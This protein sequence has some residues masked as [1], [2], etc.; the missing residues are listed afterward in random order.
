[1]LSIN[2][3]LKNVSL[4]HRLTLVNII[5][6]IAIMLVLTFLIKV[7]FTHIMIENAQKE[8][9]VRFQQVSAGCAQ[10]FQDAQ[11]ISTVLLT[12][13]EVQRWFEIDT[14][15]YSEKLRT[16]MDIESRLDYLD[17]IRFSSLFSNILI[18]NTA[19]DVVATN[20]VRKFADKQKELFTTKLKYIT[21]P[22]WLVIPSEEGT[23]SVNTVSIGYLQPYRDYLSGKII[24]YVMVLYDSHFLLSNF[25]H[26][27]YGEMGQFLVVDSST[28]E[29]EFA[30]DEVKLHVSASQ[31]HD[32]VTS[33]TD[34][35][36][37]QV[38]DG[39]DYFLVQQPIAPLDWTMIG[40]I[41][42]SDMIAPGKNIIYTIY[43]I[44]V[45]ASLIA[46]VI[47]EITVHKLMKPIHDLVLTMQAFGKSGRS[48]HVAVTSADEIGI[49]AQTY[50][51][52]TDKIQNLMEQVAIEQQNKHK[53]E[54]SALQSQVNPHFLYNVLN[55]VCSL[56]SLNEPESAIAMVHDISTFYR[57][58]LSEGKDLIPL[59]EEMENLKSYI[60]IQSFRYEDKISYSVSL[61]QELLSCQ[62]VKFTLQPLVENAIY[63]GVKEKDTEGHIQIIGSSD[64][65]DICIRIIDDGKGMNTELAQKLLAP[66]AEI[67]KGAFGLTNINK[68]I[69]LYFGKTYGLTIHSIPG[70]GTTVL[71][72]F[73][74][75]LEKEE[76]DD[77][78]T[79][80]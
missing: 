49:L 67:T 59:Q 44:G 1:M 54:L 2:N 9:A 3:K 38:L 53:F 60:K 20:A 31:L 47:N 37:I 7:I 63:H 5:P 48:N 10:V 42:V 57:T 65:K 35:K 45:L 80:C 36:G 19:G 52:M 70:S 4:S 33:G 51:T 30:S 28:A 78:G 21:K 25:M 23:K 69:Q 62:I 15:P 71:V 43:L 24:G 32:I 46:F 79:C 17:A 16:Q 58:S 74:Y 56:I 12:D 68:R 66:E 13:A 6:I 76:N 41:S 11:Q 26:L 27:Q 29:I 55:S 22:T 39:T 18:F 61:P 50:N 75:R 77:Y 64:K 40:F 34:E 14:V 73:P 8:Y 72:R